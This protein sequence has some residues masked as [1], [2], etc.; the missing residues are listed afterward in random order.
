M[1]MAIKKILRKRGFD[2]IRYHPLYD[3]LLARYAIDTVI[4]VG[5]NTGQFAQ[6]IHEKL[7]EAQIYSFEPLHDAYLELEKLGSQIPRFRAFN[8]ALGDSEGTSEIERSS[9]S[10]SSSLLHMSAQH[11]ELYPKS[12]DISKETIQVKRLDDIASQMEINGNILIKIDVQGFEDKVI[13]GGT[14]LLP[15][16]KMLIVETSFVPLY[17]SQPLFDDIEKLVYSIGFRYHGTREQ[18]WKGNTGELLYQDSIFIK[19]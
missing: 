15:R 13:K 7:P 1:L 18:H 8:F 19:R 3:T 14:S 6:E 16:A 12:A 2:I 5:A 10:P 17:E 9:F 4:D 11:K